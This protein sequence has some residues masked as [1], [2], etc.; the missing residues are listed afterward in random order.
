MKTKLCHKWWKRRYSKKYLPKKLSTYD[1]SLFILF[2]EIAHYIRKDHLKDRRKINEKELNK[3]EIDCDIRAI[4]YLKLL[5][6]KE[7]I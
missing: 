6:Q 4:K 2:H 5:K 1:H 7:S 3:Y